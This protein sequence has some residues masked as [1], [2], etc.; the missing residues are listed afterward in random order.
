MSEASRSW[1]DFGKV[2]EDNL[3]AQEDD[4]AG[5]EPEEGADS[6]ETRV[7]RARQRHEEMAA[8]GSEPVSVADQRAAGVPEGETV[9]IADQKAGTPAPDVAGPAE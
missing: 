5:N 8:E 7:E 2:I 1:P 4:R 9:T 6:D 3:Q